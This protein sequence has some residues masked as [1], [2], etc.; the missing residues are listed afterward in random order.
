MSVLAAEYL[1]GLRFTPEIS[2]SLTRRHVRRGAAAG[3]PAL[4]HPGVIRL[5]QF[6]ERTSLGHAYDEQPW[7]DLG[8]AVVGGVEDL[9]VEVIASVS[10][11]TQQPQI[12]RS[13]S[14]VLVGERVDVL[15]NEG[16][17]LGFGQD[18]G[19]SLQQARAGI[20]PGTLPLEPESGLRKRRAWRPADEQVRTF[21]SL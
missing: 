9:G 4:P 16:S 2:K 1:A 15:Q 7:P 13:A 3:H 18:T 20:E 8:H 5:G 14:P 10:D 12:G 17:W 11:L 6:G 19:V 21:P